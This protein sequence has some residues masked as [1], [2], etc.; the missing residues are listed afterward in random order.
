MSY[1][2]AEWVY[3]R[4]ARAAKQAAV[5]SATGMAVI[6]NAP[7]ERQRGYVV[8]VS[9][10]VPLNVSELARKFPGAQIYARGD[11]G[12]INL[13]VGYDVKTV[14]GPMQCVLKYWMLICVWVI[15]G[16]IW[17]WSKK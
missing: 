4:I 11:R 9:T 13:D 16:F 10:S 12:A 1:K 6:C 7:E 15:T 3:M 14:Y 5:G 8:T 2:A 17:A